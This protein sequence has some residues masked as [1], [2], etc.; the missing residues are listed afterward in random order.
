VP[1]GIET[2]GGPYLVYRSTGTIVRLGLPPLSLPV[3]G[4][5]GRPVWTDDGTVWVHRT[6]DGSF[7]AVR[8]GAAVLD[9]SAGAAPGEPGGLSVTGADPAFVGTRRD[10]AQVISAALGPPVALG[11]DVAETGLLADRDTEGRLAVVEPDRSRMVLTDTGGVPSG[12]AGGA[13]IPVD[14]G[15]GRFS[16]PV[17]SNGVIALLDLVGNRL[18]TFDTT[19]RLLGDVVLPPGGGEPELS[20][21]A[22]GTIYVDDADGAR[23]HVVGADGSVTSVATGG[24]LPDTA[25]IAAPPERIAPVAPP[26]TRVERGPGPALPGPA[27]A[28][29]PPGPPG[30]VVLPPPDQ[31]P[32]VP[33]APPVPTGVTGRVQ[34]ES[35]VVSWQPADGGGRTVSYVVRANGADPRSVDGSTATYAGPTAGVPYTF[36]VRSVVDGAE[37]R[38]SSPSAPVIVPG[39]AAAPIG[40]AATITQG[41]SFVDEWTVTWQRPDLR[42]GE[43]VRYLVAD[44]G[45]D[46]SS[47]ATPDTALT[48]ESCRTRT[49]E[50]RVV[51]RVPGDDNLVG[52][53]A[54]LEIGADRDCSIDGQFTPVVIGDGS[55]V[56]LYKD[57]NGS[58]AADA[59][60]RAT[61]NG[62]QKWSGTC[63]LDQ[64]RGAEF[65]RMDLEHDTVYDIVLTIDA[66]TPASRRTVTGPISIRTDP[67]PVSTPA[68]DCTTDPPPAGC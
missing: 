37:S 1:D 42:G 9:C 64:Y 14:L 34:G 56:A 30:D 55:V 54:V 24:R 2:V 20:R 6:D 38:D 67:A 44:G 23:T 7:C 45:S 17:A 29:P 58:G 46:R 15:P 8:A 65:A 59:P 32:V 22:D 39:R 50:V 47:R 33:V 26:P 11:T 28:P 41:G 18:L 31:S 13:A 25:A 10:A 57:F 43:F 66:V 27:P 48:I 4:P 21:G 12:R 62:V 49:V 51:T 53:P 16:S 19:G 36:T 61:A 63:S 52:D 60:C 40:L 35:I 3:G 68:P 5:V